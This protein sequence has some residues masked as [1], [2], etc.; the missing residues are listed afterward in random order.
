MQGVFTKILNL[1]IPNKTDKGTVVTDVFEPNFTKLDQYAEA[2]N[3]TLEDL[4]SNKLDKGTYTKTASDLNTEISKIAST[5]QLGRMIVGKGMTADSTGKVSVVSKN[6]GITVNDN[7]IQLN[8]VDNLTTDSSTRSLSAKQG[9]KLFDGKLDKGTYT[10]K[11]SDLKTE[12]VTNTSK[13][14]GVLGRRDEYFPLSS[15][16]K[17]AVYYLSSN[18]KFYVCVENYSG[19]SLTAPNANFEEL[20][21]FQNRNKLENLDNKWLKYGNFNFNESREVIV[22]LSN[23]PAEKIMF[24]IFKHHGIKNLH[25]IWLM[26]NNNVT[27]AYTTAFKMFDWNEGSTMQAASLGNYKT[28]F[29]FPS[30]SNY[31]GDIIIFFLN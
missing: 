11:A 14:I 15:A 29:Y 8:I 6:D 23:Y 26:S 31:T 25:S 1:W 4:K 13:I 3:Q 18:H 21:V 9:K 5:T 28:K 22:D 19:S 27:R 17:D 24:L 7:D 2:T 10:G 16:T 30:P 20:S 12:I